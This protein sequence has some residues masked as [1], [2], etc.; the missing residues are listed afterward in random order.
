[1]KKTFRYRFY[2]TPDQE[3]LL[4]RTIGCCR[5][6]YNRAL[7]IRSEAWTQRQERMSGYDLVRNLTAWKR[8]PET[9][10]LAEVSITALQQSVLD[11]DVAYRNFFANKARYPAFKRRRSGGACRFSGTAIRIRDGQVRLPKMD[12]PLDIRWSQPLPENPSRC[13]VRLTPSGEWYAMFLCEM[14]IEPLPPI[15]KRV[16]LDLG[17]TTLV[18]TSDGEK[19]ANP[20]PYRRYQQKLAKA[21]RN[22]SRKVSGSK[23]S[24]RAQLK[25]ARVHN[26]IFEIRKDQLHKLTTRLVRENQTIAI[27]DLDVQGMLGNRYL[28][29]FISDASWA[30]LR[31]ML[32]YKC[33]WFGRDLRVVDRSFPSSSICHVCGHNVGE[34]SLNVRS[35]IC[36]ECGS[37]HDRDVNAA[38]NILS[39]G[40]VDYTCGGGRET[41]ARQLVDA[42]P[43]EAGIA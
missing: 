22:L 43:V 37:R 4:R 3:S 17:I 31:E 9:E 14:E 12:E 10:W 11:L 32:T 24:L 28:A 36:P 19:L 25:V 20:K 23:R 26:K 2:P 7:A 8:E 16:G 6:V 1:M 15:D 41:E 42:S 13:T 27:E 29:G 5:Y 33:A 35:W 39:A 40:T 30:T 34:M 38:R 18:T 21:Q